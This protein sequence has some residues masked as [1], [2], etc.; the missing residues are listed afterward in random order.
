MSTRPSNKR[1][2]VTAAIATACV[3]GMTGMAFAAVPLYR[4]FCQL[5]GYGGTT[6]TADAA[7][8]QVLSETVNVRFDT[9]VAPG[10]PVEFSAEQTSETLKIGATGLAFFR[11]RNTSDQPVTAVATYNVTPETTGQYFVKLECFCFNARTLAPGEQMDLPVVY[12]VDPEFASDPETAGLDTITL[13][14]TY[15]AS[16]EEAAAALN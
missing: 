8:E 12:F 2:A 15:F 9:N 13:S 1:L 5:T 7:P 6:Q 11:V 14:Y 4:A 3:L 16:T 10:L